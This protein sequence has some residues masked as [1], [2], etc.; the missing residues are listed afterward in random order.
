MG[1]VLCR[2]YMQ[3]KALDQELLV[4]D[5]TAVATDRWAGRQFTWMIRPLLQRRAGD[6]IG[7]QWRGNGSTRQ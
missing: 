1:P 2:I 3:E 7:G 6:Q 5:P 4:A